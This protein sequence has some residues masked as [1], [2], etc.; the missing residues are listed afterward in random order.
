MDFA[1]KA[2]DLKALRA[3]A[4]RAGGILSLSSLHAKVYLIDNKRAL[5]TSANATH[6]GMHR[7]RECGYQLT[8][9]SEI[10]ALRRMLL[11]GFGK[12]PQPQLWTVQD[13][14]E[15]REPV[16]KLR[17]ALPRPIVLQAADLEAPR[18]VELRPRDYSRLINSFSGWLQLST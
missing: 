7:N 6:S 18:R 12:S 10:R 3:L 17:A 4:E 2:S 11:A 14:D 5:I 16:E 13:L 8:S 15:L 1:S 9:A